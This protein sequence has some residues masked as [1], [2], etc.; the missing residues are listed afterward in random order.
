MFIASDDNARCG[1]DRTRAARRNSIYPRRLTGES[2]LNQRFAVDSIIMS[3]GG[4]FAC[5]RITPPRTVDL[6]HRTWQCAR[7]IASTLPRPSH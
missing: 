2:G 1:S 7:Q 5:I 4:A 3:D 6:V